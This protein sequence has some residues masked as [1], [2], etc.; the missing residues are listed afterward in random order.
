MN[1]QNAILMPYLPASTIERPIY[2]YQTI[3]QFITNSGSL[4][5]YE[6]FAVPSNEIFANFPFNTL[7]VMTQAPRLN[8]VTKS[9][10]NEE[11]TILKA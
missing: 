10:T 8:M 4:N 11:T 2:N 7:N 3:P 6:I 1:W 5:H 9:E